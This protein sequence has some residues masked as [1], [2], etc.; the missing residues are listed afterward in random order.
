MTDFDPD[1][2]R[3]EVSQTAW[4]GPLDARHRYEETEEQGAAMSREAFLPC[5]KCGKTL[6]NG[7]IA[8]D[9]QPREGTEFR[10][11]GSYGSTFWD[12]FDGEELVLNVC[13]AC[14]REHTE[15]LA[16]QKRFLPIRCEGLVGLG[17]QWVDRPLV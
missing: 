3:K 6:M 8:A 10:S 16:Q 17:Q 13:D 1:A 7:F 9:N 11:Y 14:L 5:F 4:A 12:S 2:F 15:R